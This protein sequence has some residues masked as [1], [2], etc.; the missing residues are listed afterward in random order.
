M[1]VTTTDFARQKCRTRRDN[2]KPDKPSWKARN[3]PPKGHTKN[4]PL[5]YCKFSKDGVF[6]ILS[7]RVEYSERIG[8]YSDGST[9]IADNSA[10]A[11]I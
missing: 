4:I 5:V 2:P 7:S 9:V 3:K 10:N 6:H 11:H 8:L 1:R